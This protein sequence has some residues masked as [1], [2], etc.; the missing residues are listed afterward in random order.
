MIKHFS[1]ENIQFMV[2][3][4]NISQI[5]FILNSCKTMEALNLLN[6]LHFYT[7]LNVF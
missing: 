7:K 4:K 3:Q 1:K 5:E 2:Q 6:L